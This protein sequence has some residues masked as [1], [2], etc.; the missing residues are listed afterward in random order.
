M[1]LSHTPAPQ[2]LQ[3][4]VQAVRQTPTTFSTTDWAHLY[5]NI[6][7]QHVT[8]SLGFKYNIFLEFIYLTLWR[9]YGDRR[10]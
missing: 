1:S 2:Q 9:V 4:A 5:H 8:H 10:V 7:Y 3:T 6:P